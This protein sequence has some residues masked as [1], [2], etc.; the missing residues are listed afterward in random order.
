[1][2][3]PFIASVARHARGGRRMTR[4]RSLVTGPVTAVRVRA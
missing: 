4:L 3:S 1:V 2:R